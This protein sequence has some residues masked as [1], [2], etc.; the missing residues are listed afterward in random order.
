MSDK[1]NKPPIQI[2]I[3]AKAEAKF[4]VKAEVPSASAGR[5]VDAI[6]DIFRPFS[7]ARGLRADQIRLQRAEVAIE[8]ARLARQAV[9]EEGLEVQPIANKVLVPLIEKAS[10]EDLADEFMIKRWADLLVSASQKDGIPPLYAQILSEI[11]GRQATALLNVA[12]NEYEGWYLPHTIF[13]NSFLDMDSTTSRNWLP[14]R[15]SRKSF[16]SK[17]DFYRV[18]A[19]Y[20]SRP[21]C[22]LYFA[23]EEDDLDIERYLR[24]LNVPYEVGMERD[25]EICCA[26]GLLKREEIRIEYKV[27]K[28]I[29]TSDVI[30]FR[31]TG[32]GV[33]FLESCAR[34]TIGM[35]TRRQADLETEYRSTPEYK[36]GSRATRRIVRSKRST[37]IIR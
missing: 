23:S 24:G 16:S 33:E 8:I 3:G 7:E 34:D 31:L 20:F 21:G 26:I 17:E 2:D 36:K 14:L 6:T 5:F 30:Y 25:H 37:S 28:T 13:A 29:S 35:L 9:L 1:T 27:R 4:E 12:V 11:D 15:F 18:L 22:Y 19:D 10:N 32:I